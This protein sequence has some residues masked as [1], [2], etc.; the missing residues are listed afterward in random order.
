MTTHGKLGCVHM[1]NSHQLDARL[2]LCVGHSVSHMY[3]EHKW[4]QCIRQ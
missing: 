1:E 2:S 3:W 4:L